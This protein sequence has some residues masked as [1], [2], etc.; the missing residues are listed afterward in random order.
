MF[1]FHFSD[2]TKQEET[3]GAEAEHVARSSISNTGTVSD[4]ATATEHS[5]LAQDMTNCNPV[6]LVMSQFRGVEPEPTMVHFPDLPTTNMSHFMSQGEFNT[7][8]WK[9]GRKNKTHVLTF[10]TPEA[11]VRLFQRLVVSSS[12]TSQSYIEGMLKISP[13][14]VTT[15]LFQ[16]PFQFPVFVP[17]HEMALTVRTNTCGKEHRKACGP[18]PLL[19]ERKS[20]TDMLSLTTHSLPISAAVAI[21]VQMDTRGNNPDDDSDAQDGTAPETAASRKET[22]KKSMRARIGRGI[23]KFFRRLCVCGRKNERE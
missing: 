3:P 21:S 23:R 20:S 22:E 17:S 16:L 5:P 9:M 19:V 4:L 13:T 12:E 1:F 14:S 8:C 11:A 2:D 7:A 6:A 15:L 18:L 10:V